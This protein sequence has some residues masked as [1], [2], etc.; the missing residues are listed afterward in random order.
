MTDETFIFFFSLDMNK[1]WSHFLQFLHQEKKEM[2][3]DITMISNVP[4]QNQLLYM[5]ASYHIKMIDDY[6][7]KYQLFCSFS[8]TTIIL[9]NDKLTLTRIQISFSASTDLM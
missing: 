6:A 5:A 3:Q 8:S 9:L 1:V 4:W 2:A 7:R